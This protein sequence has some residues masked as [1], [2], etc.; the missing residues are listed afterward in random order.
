MQELGRLA[1]P[2][3]YRRPEATHANHL[4]DQLR[5]TGLLETTTSA[6][7][8]RDSSDPAVYQQRLTLALT[9]ALE[10]GPA[11]RSRAHDLHIM[12]LKAVTA[13]NRLALPYNMRLGQC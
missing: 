4:S 12:P 6:R 5:F 1:I 7:E 13:P 8:F 11:S 10:S 2:Y 9:V 3:C